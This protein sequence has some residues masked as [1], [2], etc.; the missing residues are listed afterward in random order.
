MSELKTL[1]DLEKIWKDVHFSSQIFNDLRQEAIKW[2][3][4][5]QKPDKE[6]EEARQ[7]LRMWI[8]KFF[9]LKGEELV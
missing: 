2:V 5:Y 9:N 4:E 8:I 6:T 7:W 3:K 1:G